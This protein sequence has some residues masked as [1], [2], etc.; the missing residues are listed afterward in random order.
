MSK[1][2]KGFTVMLCLL[3]LMCCSLAMGVAESSGTNLKFDQTEYNISKGKNQ[4][5]K[6]EIDGLAIGV[7]VKKYSWESSD[8]EIATCKDG[9]VKGVNSGSA[10]ITCKATLSDDTELSQ[11]CKVNIIVSVKSLTMKQKT[12]TVT[13]RDRFKPEI[14]IKPEDATNAELSYEIEDPSIL[15]MED[16]GFFVAQK[17]GKTKVKASST[18]GSGKSILFTVNVQKLIGATDKELT[19]QDIPWGTD[20][21]K[22]ENELYKKGLFIKN[23]P[24]PHSGGRTFFWP[25]KEY[26]IGKED[27]RDLLPE[28]FYKQAPTFWMQFFDCQKKIGGYNIN[29]FHL[30][31]K[32][33]IEN[34]KINDKKTELIG[35]KIQYWGQYLEDNSPISGFDIYIDLLKKLEEE[36]ASAKIYLNKNADKIFMFKGDKNI[37]KTIKKEFGNTTAYTGGSFDAA[38]I[39]IIKGTDDTAIVL[40]LMQYNVVELIYTKTDTYPYILEIQKILENEKDEK[41]DVGL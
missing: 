25:E 29:E 14:V 27:M 18:D 37:E 32:Y 34:N 15:I 16:T 22:V 2:L 6:V 8:K 13:A 23:Q 31:Y 7:K 36:Y 17:A 41:E 39:A 35:V 33:G 26:E 1:G 11:S 30:Y 24:Q 3:I 4:K 38:V 20:R 19:F 21:N 9:I 40:N 12:I 10:T 28:I 5:I